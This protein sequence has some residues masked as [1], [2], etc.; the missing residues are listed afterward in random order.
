MEVGDVANRSP[1]TR[2]PYNMTGMAT[3]YTWRVY[4]EYSLICK[5]LFRINEF[6]GLTGYLLL[7][8]HYIGHEKLWQIK[9][10]GGLTRI[11]CT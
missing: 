2:Q 11:H 9:R 3:G 5:N 4:S 6:G 7:L 1:G 8:V 10:F